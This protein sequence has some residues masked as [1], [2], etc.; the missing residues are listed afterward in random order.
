MKQIYEK[1][2]LVMGSAGS[3]VFYLQAFKIFADKSAIDVSLPGF[4]FGLLSVSS[5]LIYACIIKDRALLVSNI[6]ATIGAL[7]VVIGILIYS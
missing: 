3:L 5:W 7:S 6:L 1:Y 2:M 4:L